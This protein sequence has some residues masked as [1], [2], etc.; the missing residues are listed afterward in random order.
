MTDRICSS[1]G[2][3]AASDLLAISQFNQDAVQCDDQ[4]GKNMHVVLHKG[5]DAGSPPAQSS[6]LGHSGRPIARATACGRMQ[7]IHIDQAALMH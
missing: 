6:F 4:R 5:Q 1:A 2:C 7:A 3:S